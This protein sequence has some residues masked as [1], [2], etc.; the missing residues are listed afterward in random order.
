M[1]GQK[2]HVRGGLPKLLARKSSTQRRLM[3][4]PSRS[5]YR[6]LAATEP[7]PHIPCLSV[8]HAIVP[9]ASGVIKGR[10]FYAKRGVV[11]VIV[12]GSPPFRSVDTRTNGSRNPSVE[13]L[14]VDEKR[15]PSRSKRERKLSNAQRP[16]CGVE[17][18]P[19]VTSGAPDRQQ[20]TTYSTLFLPQTILCRDN[21]NHIPRCHLERF[22]S[23]SG[24]MAVRGREIMLFHTPGP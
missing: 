22:T 13:G 19:N 21:A 4:S 14:D 18:V 16:E 5:S 7:P 24:G 23:V 10:F 9:S 1:P 15:M 17:K 8:F 6:R 3:D 20:G 2:L 11:H 12:Q